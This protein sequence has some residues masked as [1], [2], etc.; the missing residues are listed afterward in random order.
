MSDAMVWANFCFDFLLSI[1]VLVVGLTVV[2][3]AHATSGYLLAGAG[4]VDLLTACCFRVEDYAQ[5]SF[6]LNVVLVFSVLGILE[7]IVYFG[8]II[9]AAYMLSGALLARKSID[10]L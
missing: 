8:L 5:Q 3:S 4:A 9:G 10:P 6:G 7:K 2:R 1:G